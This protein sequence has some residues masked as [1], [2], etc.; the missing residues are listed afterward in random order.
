MFVKQGAKLSSLLIVKNRFNSCPSFLVVYAFILINHTNINNNDEILQHCQ[1]F[2][3][4]EK[5]CMK[6]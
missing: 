2:I 6:E 3:M 4:C 1:Q 5:W